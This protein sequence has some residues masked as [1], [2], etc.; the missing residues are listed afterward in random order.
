MLE[1]GDF[2]FLGHEN[3]LGDSVFC[4]K[5]MKSATGFI[6]D[7]GY[8]FDRLYPFPSFLEPRGSS[9]FVPQNNCPPYDYRRL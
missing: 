3:L 4:E 5:N 6:A 8:K 2:P 1:C 9:Y 7:R